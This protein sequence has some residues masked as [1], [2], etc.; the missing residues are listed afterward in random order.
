[1]LA[2]DFPRSFPHTRNVCVLRFALGWHGQ[3]ADMG[4]SKREGGDWGAFLPIG[5]AVFYEVLELHGELAGRDHCLAL[6]AAK[7]HSSCAWGEGK[8]PHAPK[9]AVY[10]TLDSCH[11]HQAATVCPA[12][13]RRGCDCADDGDRDIHR[14]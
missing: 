11:R 6:L 13:L 8:E 1:M 3:R 10:G 12:P 5:R 9:V 4:E 14:L 7:E 2:A